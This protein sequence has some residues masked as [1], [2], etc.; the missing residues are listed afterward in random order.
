MFDIKAEFEKNAE[1]KKEDVEHIQ[2][3]A[4]KQPHLP[5]IT[6]MKINFFNFT[7]K[8]IFRSNIQFLAFFNYFFYMIQN[9]R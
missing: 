6:G 8:I 7:Q 2:E 5:G 9:Y 1:L 4:K 3:W